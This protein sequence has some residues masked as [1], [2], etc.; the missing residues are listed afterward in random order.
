MHSG[1]AA[2]KAGPKVSFPGAGVIRVE[3][4]GFLGAPDNDFCRRFLQTAMLTPA[5]E[6]AVIAPG[7]KPLSLIHI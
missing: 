1:P 3:S 4:A 6:A 7:D 5:I 2:G